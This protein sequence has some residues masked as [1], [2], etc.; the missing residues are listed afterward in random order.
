MPEEI[1]RAT[2][3]ECAARGIRA[4][5]HLAQHRSECR[6]VQQRHGTS[7]VRYLHDI[8]FLGPDVMATH[9]T[10]VD[11]ADIALLAAS[12]PA[13]GSKTTSASSATPNGR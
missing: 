7:P 9:A 4:H 10:Y 1:L 3:R 12:I 6:T 11:D 5:L 2:K 13:S 8:G